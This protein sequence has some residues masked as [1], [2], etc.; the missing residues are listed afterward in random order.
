M[1]G[2][3]Q[4]DD[5]RYD[6]GHYKYAAKKQTNIDTDKNVLSIDYYI[7]PVGD[8]PAT[9]YQ[10]FMEDLLRLIESKPR[11]G[12][13]RLLMY[14]RER[15]SFSIL[16]RSFN[17]YVNG[18]HYGRRLYEIGKR[19]VKYS[20]HFWFTGYGEHYYELTGS[21]LESNLVEMQIGHD[22]LIRYTKEVQSHRG[23]RDFWKESIVEFA[24]TF[25]KLED[26]S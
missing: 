1:S 25:Q 15:L 6:Q 2:S 12:F 4:E 23:E 17:A 21:Y 20:L 7:D 24:L 22:A 19:L 11:L 9:I 8:H 26:S 14:R 18:V 3:G 13:I 10:N 5:D 16:I